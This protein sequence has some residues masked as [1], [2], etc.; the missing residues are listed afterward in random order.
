[1]PVSLGTS[2]GGKLSPTRIRNGAGSRTKLVVSYALWLAMIA[3]GYLILSTYNYL[4]E[5]S[6]AENAG[7][8]VAVTT[9]STAPSNPNREMS[10]AS[11]PSDHNGLK[12]IMTT[13]TI[14]VE[15]DEQGH[16][17]SLIKGDYGAYGECLRPGDR[18]D[19]VDGRIG[20]VAWIYSHIQTRSSQPNFVV[21]D[22]DI[23]KGS[24]C[25]CM[26][27]EDFRHRG[28]WRPR[29]LGH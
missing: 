12:D 28:L 4:I 13:R 6:T 8:L 21:I 29:R 18:V 24:A 16:C 9:D 14:E 10:K 19:F 20:K 17:T 15:L 27:R 3:D 11:Q 2:S 25:S 22:I 7:R 23:V 26:N 5:R 1:M